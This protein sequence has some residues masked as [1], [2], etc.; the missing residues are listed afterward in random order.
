MRHLECMDF[1]RIWSLKINP[2]DEELEEAHQHLADC[3]DCQA[4]EVELESRFVLKDYQTPGEGLAYFDQL[5]IDEAIF[6]DPLNQ[7][8]A[9]CKQRVL[10][11]LGVHPAVKWE[12]LKAFFLK[13][14]YSAL[15]CQP[16]PA[17]GMEFPPPRASGQIPIFEV[18]LASE[19]RTGLSGLRNS[20]FIRE[21]QS[22]RMILKL[23][24]FR[25]E[26]AGHQALFIM[27]PKPVVYELSGMENLNNEETLLHIE[28]HLQD[29]ISENELDNAAMKRLRDTCR[30]LTG[31]LI[32]EE[33]EVTLTI[34]F[35]DGFWPMAN[36]PDTWFIL[37]ISHIP[38]TWNPAQ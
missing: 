31:N 20:G 13:S 35:S 36:H 32:S 9:R 8:M 22:D 38:I 30:V 14:I 27:V 23:S 12:V 25:P 24:G 37:I 2:T 18:N 33:A 3:L 10:Q 15:P 19:H 5:L 17:T 16:K 28:K 11:N 1:R 34:R 26:L 6:W 4:L 29:V 7:G 21:P